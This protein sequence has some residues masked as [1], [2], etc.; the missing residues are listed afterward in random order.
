MSTHNV[1]FLVQ[2][3]KNYHFLLSLS[4]VMLATVF[5]W[6]RSVIIQRQTEI[7]LAV[8]TFHGI[9]VFAASVPF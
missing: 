7:V 1:C 2:N 4:E 6:C 3:N 9:G 8:G 5:I